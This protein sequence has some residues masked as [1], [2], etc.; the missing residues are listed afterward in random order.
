MEISQVFRDAFTCSLSK[1]VLKRRFLVSGLTK[2]VAVCNFGNTLGMTIIFFFKCLKLDVDS[3]IGIKN[4]KK[5]IV[6]KIIAFELG[7]ANS[8]NLEQ[9]T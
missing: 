2:I 1:R 7:F 3:R 9:D 5:F 8:H 4:E 6:F